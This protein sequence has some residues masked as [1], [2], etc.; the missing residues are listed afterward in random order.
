MST[1]RR[2][3]MRREMILTE[4]DRRFLKKAMQFFNIR[5]LNVD[6]SSSPKKYPDIWVTFDKV[7]TITVTDEW[8][9]HSAGLRRS[10]LVHEILH[11]RG[12]KHGKVGKHVYSTYPSKDTYSKVVY[13]EILRTMG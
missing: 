2:L 11:V 12:L 9:S 3:G 1:R 4:G 10:Q 13:K 8:K 7:P 5:A 6:Y